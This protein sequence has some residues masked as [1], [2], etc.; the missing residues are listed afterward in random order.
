MSDYDNARPSA[1]LT[2]KQRA[3][4]LALIANP[5]V[6]NAAKEA[7]VHRATVHTWMKLPHFV[8]ELRRAE[9]EMVD[10]VSRLLIRFAKTAVATIAPRSTSV[11]S[12]WPRRTG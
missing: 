11:R 6:E 9:D 2:P 3:A 8:A 10:E 4:I 5:S 7:G 12:R 1:T